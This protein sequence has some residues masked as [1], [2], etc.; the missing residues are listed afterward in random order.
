[1]ILISLVTKEDDFANLRTGP[2]SIYINLIR[3]PQAPFTLISAIYK[4]P[5]LVPK[6]RPQRADSVPGVY[7][8]SQRQIFPDTL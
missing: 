8:Y 5:V 7:V 4:W 2:K 3:E 1:M 6:L